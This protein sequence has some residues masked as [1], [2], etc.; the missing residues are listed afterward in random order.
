M[1]RF[2]LYV[3]Q[4]PQHILAL[5]IWG[6]LKVFRRII[7]AKWS[8]GYWFITVN[9]PGWGVSLGNYIFLDRKYGEQTIR[10]ELGHC[11][12]SLWLGPLYLLAIGIPSAIFNNLWDRLFHRKWQVEKRLKWY[13]SRFPEKQA[14]T[15]G[16]VERKI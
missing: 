13:Y 2:F 15:L 10:H 8:D 5:I 6:V 12:Q 14:D 3:W 1:R 7:K 9:A 4:L 11:I 16:G